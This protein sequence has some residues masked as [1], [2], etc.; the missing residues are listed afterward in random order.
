MRTTVASQ[1]TQTA[2][3]N[4]L[5]PQSPHF[6]HQQYIPNLP[7]P[8]QQ[9][10]GDGKARGLASKF[11]SSMLSLPF[12]TDRDPTPT[13]TA[14]GESK[15]EKI[16]RHRVGP[17]SPVIA[18]NPTVLLLLIYPIRFDYFLVSW[19]LLLSLLEDNGVS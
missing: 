5:K 18:L 8:W 7:L 19:F 3:G 6:S 15:T 11:I 1:A 4:P 12:T 10:P 13:A 9:D 16:S 14:K 2:L 17:M